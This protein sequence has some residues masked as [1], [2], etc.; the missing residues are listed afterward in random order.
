MEKIAPL[1]FNDIGMAF[2]WTGHNGIIS[3]KVQLVFIETGFYFKPSEM[4]TFISLIDQAANRAAS[5]CQCC[6]NRLRCEKFLL[7][8]PIAQID[9]AVSE[10]ELKGIRDLVRG[11]IFRLELY[12]FLKAEGRN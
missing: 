5:A 11:T 2:Y 12:R 6:R 1:Y 9:L 7:K 3:N 10:Y 4:E 8:T